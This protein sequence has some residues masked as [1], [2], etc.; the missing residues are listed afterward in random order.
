MERKNAMNVKEI[1]QYFDNIDMVKLSKK[2]VYL[3][4]L[5]GVRIRRLSPYG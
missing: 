1:T 5:G 2:R 3:Y 4:G